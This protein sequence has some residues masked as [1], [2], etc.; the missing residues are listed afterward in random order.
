V[1]I[2]ALADFFCGTRASNVSRLIDE[3]RKANGKARTTYLS[4]R[5]DAYSEV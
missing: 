5:N 1:I 2:A 3:L 4:P